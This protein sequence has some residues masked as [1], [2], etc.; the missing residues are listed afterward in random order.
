MS[1]MLEELLSAHKS[2]GKIIETNLETIDKISQETKNKNIAFITTVARGTSNH[3]AAF[4][5]YICELKSGIMVSR[6][7]HSVT[8][9]AGKNVDMSKALLSAY[10]KAAQAMTLLRLCKPPKNAERL[11][12]PLPTIRP[13]HLPS[14]ATITFI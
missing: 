3:A 6:F 12:S 13:L 5:K 10:P 2:L 11:P 4:F 9:I 1:L 8:T 14:F 7:N